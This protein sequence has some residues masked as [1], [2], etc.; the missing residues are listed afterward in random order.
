MQVRK[1]FKVVAVSENTNSFG[2]RQMVMV[3]KDG[4]AFR[5]CFNSLN[6]KKK[7][8]VIV[9]NVTV[10]DNGEGVRTEFTGGELVEKLLSPPLD[11][12]REIW[13]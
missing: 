3:A 6:E 4:S 13:K 5:G 10:R 11:T 12:I 8:E 1:E 2:L 9:G 7:D